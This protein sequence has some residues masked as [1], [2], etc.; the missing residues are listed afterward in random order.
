VG[1]SPLTVG[2]TSSVE[3]SHCDGV[4]SFEWSFGD[5][6]TSS[7][8][9]PTYRYARAG[10]FAW[11]LTVA[12]GG[13]TCTRTGSVSVSPGVPGDCDGDREVTIGELQRAVNMFL[14]I[15]PPACGA[16]CDGDGQLSIGEVQR[17]VNAFLGLP[18]GCG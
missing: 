9:N 18:S 3:A 17:A 4:P 1:S 8:P 5:G 16:D 2:F 14:G 7:E 12:Q 10:V 13:A 15:E 6:G 11:G